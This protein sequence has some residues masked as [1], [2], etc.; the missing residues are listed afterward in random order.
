MFQSLAD[1]IS[2]TSHH[3]A[4]QGQTRDLKEWRTTIY[5]SIMALY[6]H[7]VLDAGFFQ[8]DPHPGNWFWKPSLNEAGGTLT[9]IDWGMSDD[10]SAGYGRAGKA[11]RDRKGNLLRGDDGEEIDQDAVD[12]IIA[13][14]KCMT[15][16]FYKKL[17]LH[18][19]RARVCKGYEVTSKE[20][21]SPH[22]FVPGGASMLLHD[23]DVKFET[24]YRERTMSSI[25]FER[26]SKEDRLAFDL[27][28]RF[29]ARPGDEKPFFIQRQQKEVCSAE[30]VFDEN[31]GRSIEIEK[32]GVG[33]EF[34]QMTA[35]A[36]A[37]NLFQS[38]ESWKCDTTE[39]LIFFDEDTCQKCDEND[40]SVSCY[41]ECVRGTVKLPAKIG[42]EFE[43]RPAA[44]QPAL[45]E[46]CDALQPSEQIYAE[47]ALGLGYRT[48]TNQT[49]ILALFT[50]LHNSDA[51]A[52]KA[53]Q[54]HLVKAQLKEQGVKLPDFEAIFLRCM[55]VFLGM[56][57]DMVEMNSP[58][59]VPMQI[60]E[61]LLDNS[62]DEPMT[63]WGAF[64][65]GK[66]SDES[67]CPK[68]TQVD[69]HA[70]PRGKNHDP[71]F[72]EAALKEFDDWSLID[73]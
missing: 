54:D 45:K 22:L 67:E 23:A 63:L 55:Q 14:N 57:Q 26:I 29:G 2:L 34:A 35:A 68:H 64:V 58:P 17:T 27:K 73:Q 42:T 70:T 62:E 5:P 47:G 50:E 61:F 53:R 3:A 24:K 8:G 16:Q 28:P 52:L 38:K 1:G 31:L 33:L 44:Q 20:W 48:K 21:Q 32:C 41:K 66:G 69:E 59:F 36:S 71:G 4:I 72:V 60:T 43:I 11:A 15:K 30:E 25:D 6:G 10:F 13:R 51:L 7:L 18:H 39:C 49:D 19:E 9:L 46:M 12:Q 40:R 65:E 37:E 56:I